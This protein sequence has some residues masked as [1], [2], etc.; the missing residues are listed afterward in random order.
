MLR[1]RRGLLDSEEQGALNM[2]KK[3]EAWHRHWALNLTAQ[4]PE[5]IEDARLIASLVEELVAGFLDDVRTPQP[6]PK[7]LKVVPLDG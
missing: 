6:K 1:R 7:P 4:L 2:P 3:I 5:E